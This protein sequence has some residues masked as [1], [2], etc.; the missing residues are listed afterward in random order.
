MKLCEYCVTNVLESKVSWDYHSHSYRALEVESKFQC[1]FC[2]TLREDIKRVAPW[3][4]E[5]DYTGTWPIYRWSI[6]SLVKIRE[7][8]E[9]VVVTFRYVPPEKGPDGD[10]SKKDDI[11]LQKRTFFLFPENGMFPLISL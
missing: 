10:S 2:S 5:S 11:E 3:L 8:P 1:L 6:R 4:K 9:T 7:S